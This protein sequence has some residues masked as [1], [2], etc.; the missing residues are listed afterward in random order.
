[1][2]AVAFRRQFQEGLAHLPKELIINS[3]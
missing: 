2:L 3:L 1:V